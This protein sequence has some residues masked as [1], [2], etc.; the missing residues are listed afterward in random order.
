MPLVACDQA[1]EVP[2]ESDAITNGETNGETEG[3]TNGAADD[4]PKVPGVPTTIPEDDYADKEIVRY[5][6]NLGDYYMV[7]FQVTAPVDNVVG[8]S[9]RYY[10]TDGTLLD[11]VDFYYENGGKDLVFEDFHEVYWVSDGSAIVIVNDSAKT[12]FTLKDKR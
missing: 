1:D 4:T 11:S 6:S 10:A 2:G 12:R 8:A 7:L 3:T 5:P 9:L